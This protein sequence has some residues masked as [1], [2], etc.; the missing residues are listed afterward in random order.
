M[1]KLLY[2]ALGFGAGCALSA[3]VLS[4][5]HLWIGGIVALLLA[6]P[7]AAISSESRMAFAITLA[8]L[9]CAGGL[10]RYGLFHAVYL[11]EA[12][13]VDGEIRSVNIHTTDYSRETDYGRSVD[14]S[15]SLEGR[16]YNVRAYLNHGEEVNPGSSLSGDFL[17]RFTVADGEEEG[18]YHPGRGIFLLAYHLGYTCRHG[19]GRNACGAD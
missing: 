9:G 7:A 10:L 3:Y 17:L 8:L 5:E 2:I 14:G 18:T 11:E 4:A 12:A 1:R 16:T 6:I 19:N 13:S 15:I